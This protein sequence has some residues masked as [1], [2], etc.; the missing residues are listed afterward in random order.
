MLF[1]F[2]P[3]VNFVSPL[4]QIKGESKPKS[5]FCA[6][7]VCIC[8]GLEMLT[9]YYFKIILKRKILVWLQ[10]CVQEDDHEGSG[11][12]AHF[13]AHAGQPLSCMAFDPR[14]ETFCPKDLSIIII[15]TFQ[16]WNFYNPS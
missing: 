11:I 8:S 10:F 4:T 2:D 3:C 1:T 16:I 13:P 12:V 15:Q 14:Y 7:S 6:V 9:E 5:A